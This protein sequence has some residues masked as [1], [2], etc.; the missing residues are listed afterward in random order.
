ML[1]RTQENILKII[2]KGNLDT[3]KIASE[4]KI[5]KNKVNADVLTLARKK[6]I[7]NVKAVYLLKGTPMI[8]FL[9]IGFGSKCKKVPLQNN[10]KV[11]VESL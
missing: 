4:L 9:G 1:T 10:D 5:D 3:S 7:D 6:E 8:K 2:K 11:G